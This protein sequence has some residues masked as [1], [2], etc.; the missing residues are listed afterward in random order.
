MPKRRTG[1]P[2]APR[3]KQANFTWYGRTLGSASHN[4]Q[5]LLGLN[6]QANSTWVDASVP[7]RLAGTQAQSKR[8]L[9]AH[10]VEALEAALMGRV[11]KVDITGA[12]LIFEVSADAYDHS[13]VKQQ[14]GML[15][16]PV[17]A[18][19]EPLNA[20]IYTNLASTSSQWAG[21]AGKTEL[22]SFVAVLLMAI[23]DY[24]LD[25]HSAA[26]EVVSAY[27]AVAQVLHTMGELPLT[28]GSQQARSLRG[29]GAI[30]RTRI[31]NLEGLVRTAMDALYIYAAYTREKSYGG[32]PT[33]AKTW[34]L[35]HRGLAAVPNWQPTNLDMAELLTD[36]PA[37]SGFLNDRQ[38]PRQATPA[39]TSQ[40]S[41]QP[42]PP[43]PSQP[44][45]SSAPPPPPPPQPTPVPQQTPPRPRSAFDALVIGTSLCVA[46]TE[47]GC[48]NLIVTGPPAGG[49]TTGLLE[50]SDQMPTVMIELSEEMLVRD[51]VA[52]IERNPDGTWGPVLHPWGQVCR[53]AM[54]R[55][56]LIALERGGSVKET[57][58]KY[59]QS[60]PTVVK[61][62]KALASKPGDKDAIVELDKAAKPEYGEQWYPIDS[63]YWESGAS[64]VGPVFR[65]I[66]DEIFDGARNRKL[67]TFLKGIM[68]KRRLFSLGIAG[69]APL[70]AL[71][72]HITAAGNASAADKFQSAV[73]SRFHC[74]YALS[75]PGKQSLIERAKH[76]VKTAKESATSKPKPEKPPINFALVEHSF[77][78]PVRKVSD[79]TD[80]CYDKLSELSE[81]TCTQFQARRFAEPIDARGVIALASMIAHMKGGGMSEKA[82]FVAAGQSVVSKVVK[83]DP[84]WGLPIE[85]DKN[86]M[87]VKIN[88]LSSSLR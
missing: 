25:G 52:N 43:P 19:I 53:T 41:P 4:F 55:A 15:P 23:N 27:H 20:T 82:A 17:V 72:V 80:G 11:S 14:I 34:A 71:N 69:A 38:W 51:I 35:E 88:A 12:T 65:F 78:P 42:P 87:L 50:A 6:L 40:P 31:S 66:F 10:G 28:G 68:A 22:S 16:G 54:L 33:R 77:V 36:E 5:Q 62:L 8:T 83:I 64:Q 79:L 45:Q 73:I 13:V 76:M 30:A 26:K 7:A 49:K 70:T 37:L 86:D 46:E 74:S 29:G 61:I 44:A 21:N 60:Q 84:I 75:A 2:S 81:F 57:L 67:N 47:G 9:S 58:K 24:R 85:Q 32:S 63:A 39:P 59:R 1:A 56:L 3:Q 18:G 48:A